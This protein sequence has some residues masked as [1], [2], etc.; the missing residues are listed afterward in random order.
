MTFYMKLL[1]SIAYDTDK[2]QAMDDED[3]IGKYCIV[4]S[5]TKSQKCVSIIYE[6]EVL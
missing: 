3:I 4:F 2:K 6:K 1:F 5:Q